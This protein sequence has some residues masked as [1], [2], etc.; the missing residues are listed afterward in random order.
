M[1]TNTQTLPPLTRPL[2]PPPITTPAPVGTAVNLARNLPLRSVVLV[3]A[4]A[5]VKITT[6]T[7]TTA[8][9]IAQVRVGSLPE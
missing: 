9:T 6:M 3:K 8:T 1:F 4:Q 5:Q 2:L 7:H